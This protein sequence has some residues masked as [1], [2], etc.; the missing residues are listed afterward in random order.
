[1]KRSNG[2]WSAC[3]PTP[4]ASRATW[5]RC[6]ASSKGP[7]AAGAD[8]AGRVLE[9]ALLRAVADRQARLRGSEAGGAVGDGG[10]RRGGDPGRPRRDPRRQERRRGR[11]RRDP[12]HAGPGLRERAGQGDRRAGL[13]GAAL[14]GRRARARIVR[15][16]GERA[17]RDDARRGGRARSGSASMSTRRRAPRRGRWPRRAGRWRGRSSR[18]CSGS[19]IEAQKHSTVKSSG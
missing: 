3:A 14:S 10:D 6:A 8:Q 1:M 11:P 15:A 9:S 4:V 13:A 2:C 12:R 16:G 17:D 7:F 5:R 19:R 18:L